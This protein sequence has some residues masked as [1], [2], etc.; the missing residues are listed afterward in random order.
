MNTKLNVKYMYPSEE[1][2]VI[3]VV[4]LKD[5]IEAQHYRAKLA[6]HT[7]KDD[8]DAYQDLLCCPCTSM[9][10]KPIGKTIT[11]YSIKSCDRF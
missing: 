11:P 9:T 7:Y 4:S 2:D 6:G 1:G 10:S 8:E 5:A 3:E